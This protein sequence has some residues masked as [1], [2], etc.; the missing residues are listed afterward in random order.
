MINQIYK[1]KEVRWMQIPIPGSFNGAVLG[2]GM[3]AE[4][5]AVA[6]LQADQSLEDGGGGG[7]G[8]RNHGT[9]NADGFGNLHHTVGGILFQNA[10]GLLMLIS[11]IDILRSIVVLNDL[12]FH[13]AHAGFGNS[14]LSQIDTGLIGSSGSSQEDLIHLFLGVSSKLGLG[15]VAALQHFLKLLGIG[16]GIFHKSTFFVNYYR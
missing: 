2:S 13:H 4:N 14:H 7:I 5:N 9:D 12:I 3:G 10:A 11:V 8:G 1:R 16:N 6:G 15:C